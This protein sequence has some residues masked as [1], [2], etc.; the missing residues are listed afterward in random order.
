MVSTPAVPTTVT[1]VVTPVNVTVE[2][3][4]VLVLPERSMVVKLERLAFELI[5]MLC[6][7]AVGING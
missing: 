6:V 1:E 5:T 2:V 4:P 3:D 7:L